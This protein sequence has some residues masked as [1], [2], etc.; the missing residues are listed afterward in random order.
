MSA[1]IHDSASFD[2]VLEQRFGRRTALKAALGA[3]GAAVAA[4]LGADAVAAAADNSPYAPG[5]LTYDAVPQSGTDAIVLPDGFTHDIVISWGDP[6]VPG[7]PAFDIQNQTGAA[8]EQQCGFNHD[9]LAYLPI[10]WRR[11]TRTT[12]CCGSTTSTPTSR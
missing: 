7:A 12:A 6:V 1:E 5:E 9:Y 10:Q 2:E 3:G 4:T 8:Q 11:R